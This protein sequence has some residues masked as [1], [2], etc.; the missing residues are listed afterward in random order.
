VLTEDLTVCGDL[1]L[2]I[3]GSENSAHLEIQQNSAVEKLVY[4]VML[5]ACLQILEGEKNHVHIQLFEVNK[6][7]Q[8]T[9]GL[10]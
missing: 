1:K 9:H 6:I 5:K 7:K 4:Y 2:E 3:T 10:D 8:I